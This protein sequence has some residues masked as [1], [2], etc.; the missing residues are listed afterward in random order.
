MRTLLLGEF[1]AD[2]PLA[3]SWEHLARVEEWPRWAPH[4]RG[5]T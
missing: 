2:V 4:V 5:W 1:V 3:A